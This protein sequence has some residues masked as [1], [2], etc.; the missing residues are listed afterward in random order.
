M[1]LNITRLSYC[2]VLTLATLLCFACGSSKKITTK[3]KSELQETYESIKKEMAEAEV[4]LLDDRIKV[5]LPEAVLFNINESDIHKEYLPILTSMGKLLN[6]YPKTSILITGF[7]DNTGTDALNNTLSQ[8]RAESAAT[9]LE[10][11]GVDKGRL[12]TWGLGKRSPIA[13][14]KTETGRKQNR[15]VEYVI[16]Y[17][18]KAE[19]STIPKP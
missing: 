12:H 14:N 9:V 3:Q 4:T 8:K 1:N 10:K 19:E 7:T 5:V 18:Y 16:L 15:R 6:R 17:N 2:L 11:A 13:D